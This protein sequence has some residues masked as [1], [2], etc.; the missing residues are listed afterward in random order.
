MRRNRKPM[1]L[2]CARTILVL[3]L[4][5]ALT[6]PVF[7]EVEVRAGETYVFTGAEFTEDDSLRGVFVTAVPAE[8]Q[9][10]LL[11]GDR[12]LRA[13]DALSRE[14]LSRISLVPM[15]DA[16]LE[17]AVCFL[18]ILAD[19]LGE[20]AQ[21][22]MHIQPSADEPPVALDL[23][24][25]TYR[26]IPAEGVLRA[27]W[28]GEGQLT[29]RLAE[30]PERGEVELSED[31]TFTYTPHKNK[32]GEDSFTFVAA[33]EAGNESQ[34]GVVRIRIEKPSDAQTFA[35]L[36]L[37]KQFTPLW[38]REAGLF[39]GETINQRLS[40]GPEKTVTRGEF[41]AMLMALQGID[42]E[43]GLQSSGF[44]DENEAAQWVRPYLA[45]AMRRGIARGYRT[46]DGLVFRP[47]QPITAGEASLL[48]ARTLGAEPA[49]PVAAV[50]A[51]EDMS[52]EG[53]SAAGSG[54]L[55]TRME[56]ADLLYLVSQQ[57]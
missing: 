28:K 40:F 29:F 49:R 45:S 51:A 48:V 19:G 4:L 13:G 6:L 35:D 38:L 5:L 23:S 17:T 15:K 3:S 46:E 2:L 18:P 1:F 43:I 37:G 25:E 33:D 32:V 44:S 53:G 54:R 34:P 36:P 14:D 50:D 27:D 56:A 39:G 22:T 52:A 7:A 10:K 41:L 24:L 9:A 57:S 55:L 16:E 47:N 30:G 26:N 20:T 11:L 21:L 12:V 42:P 31:G 8:D